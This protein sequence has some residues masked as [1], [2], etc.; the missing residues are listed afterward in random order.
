MYR[1]VYDNGY[2]NTGITLLLRECGIPKGSLY[3]HFKSKK[4]IMICVIKERLTPYMDS[5]FVSE[6][7]S[8]YETILN[9]LE[10]ISNDNELISKNCPYNRINMEL[11]SFD[12]DFKYELN[13]IFDSVAKRL[14]LLLEE[15]KDEKIIKEVDTL[16]L[17]EY[18]LAV[19]WGSLNVSNS[20]EELD[21]KL[22]HLHNYINSLKI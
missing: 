22:Q 8:A 10:F 21:S 6:N 2:S 15:M 1:L 3:H 5:L 11:S 17:A 16:S 14:K 9:T 13:I 7:L 20:K 12:E 19:I 4:D 18:I